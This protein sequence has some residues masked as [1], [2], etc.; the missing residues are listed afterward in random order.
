MLSL[1]SSGVSFLNDREKRNVLKEQAAEDGAVEEFYI[2][3]FAN[4]YTETVKTDS[5]EK[6]EI[7]GMARQI[8]KGFE[9]AVISVCTELKA[10][11]TE[12]ALDG[13]K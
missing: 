13:N 5:S 11:E 7:L 9:G 1:C 8:E 6:A 4:G 2:V 3:D 10:E 12:K